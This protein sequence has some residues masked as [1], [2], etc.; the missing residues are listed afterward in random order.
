MASVG[1]VVAPDMKVYVTVRSPERC[2]E[3]VTRSEE[4]LVQREWDASDRPAT[5]ARSDR[6]GRSTAGAVRAVRQVGPGPAS[7]P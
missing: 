6:A 4:R 3:G 5:R 1:V 7:A 2:R